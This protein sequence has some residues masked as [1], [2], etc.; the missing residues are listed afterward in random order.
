MLFVQNL[1]SPVTQYT[2]MYF[3]LLQLLQC[4]AVIVTD[5][6]LYRATTVD[7]TNCSLKQGTSWMPHNVNLFSARSYWIRKRDL[8]GK[9]AISTRWL[10]AKRF[11]TLLCFELASSANAALFIAPLLVFCVKIACIMCVNQWR[12][13]GVWGGLPP[14]CT[15]MFAR[16]G[17]ICL[18]SWTYVQFHPRFWSNWSA[19]SCAKGRKRS[20]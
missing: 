16:V 6:I 10:N 2:H 19:H 18:R 1:E 15:N 8:R 5:C 7:Y 17:S 12:T 4:N 13:V 14:P 9:L 11:E 20:N 3:M